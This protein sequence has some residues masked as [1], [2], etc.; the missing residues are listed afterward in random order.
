MILAYQGLDF[1][2]LAADQY[3][4]ITNLE[5]GKIEGEYTQR[6]ICKGIDNIYAAFIGMTK[7][8]LRTGLLLTP[9]EELLTLD[10]T[11]LHGW[12]GNDFGMF[13][14]DSKKLQLYTIESKTAKI[15]KHNRG[16]IHLG[17]PIVEDISII[18]DYMDQ[19]QQKDA[20]TIAAYFLQTLKKTEKVCPLVRGY[21]VYIFSKNRVEIYAKSNIPTQP[22]RE[23]RFDIIGDE[24][25][26]G[27][28]ISIRET[29]ELRALIALLKTI[30]IKDLESIPN[31]ISYLEK[32]EI[33]DA[34]KKMLLLN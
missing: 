3:W 22:E 30:E 18:L 1:I 5:T 14:V 28:D 9:L 8:M 7:D 16:H 4:Q 27:K 34:I 31:L 12:Q 24:P 2:V 32:Y 15:E 29:I 21:D 11:E 33:T 19:L 20:Q 13:L 23:I 26:N 6:K 25:Y 10:Y 17:T